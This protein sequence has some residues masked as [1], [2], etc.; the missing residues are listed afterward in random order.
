M[1]TIIHNAPLALADPDRYEVWAELMWAGNVAHNGLLGKGREEDWAS[2]NIEHELSALYD[3]AHGAGLAI[4][5]PAWMKAVSRRNPARFAQFA[6]RVFGIEAEDK[7]ED[8]LAAL[9]I[10]CL[11]NFFRRLGLF[12]PRSQRPE[13]MTAS[14]HEWPDAQLRAAAWEVWKNWTRRR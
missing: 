1:K 12:L 7:R 6:E 8:E 10:S 5:F 11:E 9:G 2:H 14:F 4:V 13:S 3:I